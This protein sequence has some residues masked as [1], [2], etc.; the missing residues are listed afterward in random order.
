MRPCIQCLNRLPLIK[1]VFLATFFSF[2]CLLAIPAFCQYELEVIT[3]SE[4]LAY[5]LNNLGNEEIPK[6]K[7]KKKSKVIISNPISDADLSISLGDEGH[8]LLVQLKKKKWK[9]SLKLRVL[10]SD[11]NQLLMGVFSEKKNILELPINMMG[12]GEFS[13]EITDYKNVYRQVISIREKPKE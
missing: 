4:I 13:I 9:N 1:T 6:K 2:F 11:Q 12:S 10:N 5:D 3:P 7:S 8:T